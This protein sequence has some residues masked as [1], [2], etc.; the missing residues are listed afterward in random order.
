MADVACDAYGFIGTS[1][2]EEANDY[3]HHGYRCAITGIGQ[4]DKSKNQN[5]NA[6]HRKVSALM[7]AN[8]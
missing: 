3:R 6:P 1:I 8:F 4:F 2:E 5:T 7:I